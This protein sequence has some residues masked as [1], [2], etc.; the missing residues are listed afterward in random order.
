MRVRNSCASDGCLSGVGSA[1][2]GV[3]GALCVIT[4]CP[5]GEVAAAD[6]DTVAV[7]ACTG[8]GVPGAPDRLAL[9]GDRLVLPDSGP[10]G[11]P[12]D[13]PWAP[14]FLLLVVAAGAGGVLAGLAVLA[15][16]RAGDGVCCVAAG[17]I[18]AGTPEL[19]PLRAH[20][21]GVVWVVAAALGWST[22]AA[23]VS[24]C[25]GKGACAGV[26][27][28]ACEVVGAGA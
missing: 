5:L 15:G 17:R 20:A 27:A 4:F 22:T 25:G 3:A 19:P 26:G 7:A 8:G 14:P 11:E 10:P 12:P 24:A 21:F 18:A 2:S 28:G 16:A 1:G 13:E 9:P 23:A 6:V